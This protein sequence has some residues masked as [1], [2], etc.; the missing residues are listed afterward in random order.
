MRRRPTF[1]LALVVGAL[2]ATAAIATPAPQPNA[3]PPTAIASPLD[4]ATAPAIADHALASP[5]AFEAS[6]MDS[7]QLDTKRVRHV[8]RRGGVLN[9]PITDTSWVR[10]APDH[11]QLA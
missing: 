7:A 1:L 6:Y 10:S 11:P 8:T 9:D 3:S 4:L 2:F 5:V